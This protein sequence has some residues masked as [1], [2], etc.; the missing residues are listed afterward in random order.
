MM[1]YNHFFSI[2]SPLPCWYLNIM[3]VN[4]ILLAFWVNDSHLLLSQIQC[5]DISGLS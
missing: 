5:A 3:I 2:W 4:L 1:L